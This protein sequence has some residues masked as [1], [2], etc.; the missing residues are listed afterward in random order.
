MKVWQKSRGNRVWFEVARVRVIGS[1]LYYYF[2]AFFSV[3]RDCSVR[4]WLRS[5]SADFNNFWQ[6]IKSLVSPTIILRSLYKIK[7]NHR[8]LHGIFVLNTE[9]WK[10]IESLWQ[11]HVS[12]Q[13]LLMYQQEPSWLLVSI[14]LHNERLG[15]SL[16]SHSATLHA[17]WISRVSTY[18]PCRDFAQKAKSRGGTLVTRAYINESTYSWNL[19]SYSQYRKNLHLLE[20]GPWGIGR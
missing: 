13:T 2:I 1:R 10:I 15:F 3:L 11:Q 6:R 16:T 9:H 4:Y 14:N 5:E 12:W 17:W 8:V 18:C 20:Q 7:E 19:Q